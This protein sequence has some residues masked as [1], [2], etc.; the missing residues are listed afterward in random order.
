MAHNKPEP[1]IYPTLCVLSQI[2]CQ[3][4]L[5]LLWCGNRTSHLPDYISA[6]RTQDRPLPE[7]LA[8]AAVP[9]VVDVVLLHCVASTLLLTFYTFDVFRNT[10]AAELTAS[11]ASSLA[12]LPKALSLQRQLLAGS[13]LYKQH[14][15][16]RYLADIKSRNEMK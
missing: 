2:P 7:L 6:P 9:A 13:G 12:E 14:R 10:R 5:L 11:P 16:C 15:F 8:F 4:L 3:M 1:T